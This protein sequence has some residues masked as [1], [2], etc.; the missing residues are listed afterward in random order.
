[1][2]KKNGSELTGA[3]D[4]EDISIQ[5]E[6]LDIGNSTTVF[7]DC[8]GL[9]FRQD[10]L[11]AIEN[12]VKEKIEKQLGKKVAVIASK[13]YRINT[14]DLK[15]GDVMVITL[16]PENMTESV[17][18]QITYQIDSLLGNTLKHKQIKF[19]FFPAGIHM[20]NIDKYKFF[21]A[22]FISVDEIKKK[23]EKLY[24]EIDSSEYRAKFIKIISNLFSEY[25]DS[26]FVVN[27]IDKK[28]F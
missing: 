8:F 20:D 1:M 22:G 3:F 15:K 23:I 2:S 14:F 28:W 16:P 9:P 19:I 21:K 17:I 13:N 27:M 11:D 18:N 25:S 24:S 7:I 4:S 26:S 12:S 6:A 10:V 5:L